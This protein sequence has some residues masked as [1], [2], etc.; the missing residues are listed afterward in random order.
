M[1]QPD[2]FDIQTYNYDLPQELI[3]QKPVSPRDSCRLMVID[4][5][6]GHID[7]KHFFDVLSFFKPGDV[8]VR[9]DTRV[10]AARL[11]GIKEGGSARCEILL[12]RPRDAAE[13]EWEALV[14]PG[15]KLPE[16][17]KVCLDGGVTVSVGAVLS[18]DGVRSVHFPQDCDVRALE[19]SSGSMPLPPY[20]H[21]RS[22]SPEDYQTVYSKEARSAAAP[23]AGLHFTKELLDK[24]SDC[25]VEIADITLEVGIGTF[26]PVK[27]TDIRQHVMHSER[28]VIPQSAYDKISAAKSRGSRVVALGTTVVRTLEGMAA[29]PGGLRPGSLETELFIYPGF[30]YQVVDSLITNFHLPQSTLLMLVAAFA[31]YDLTMKAYKEAVNRRY[32]FFSFGDAMMIL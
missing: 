13:K 21:E 27:T 14:R 24:V 32:R 17:A 31:G 25:G 15:R 20:I 2:F 1:N 29:T 30:K 5:K 16:G 28:C 23:T 22:S 12:L 9:N 19:E 7:H 26:R 4:R 11:E 8:L 10:M 18:S 6:S 3:A